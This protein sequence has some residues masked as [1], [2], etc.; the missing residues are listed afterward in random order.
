MYSGRH[1]E[2]HCLEKRDVLNEMKIDI[3]NG[4]AAPGQS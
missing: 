1:Y 3:Q 4:G 2:T